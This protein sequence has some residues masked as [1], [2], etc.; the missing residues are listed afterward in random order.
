MEKSTKKNIL[1]VAIIIL[2][3]INISALATIFYN[4]KLNAP[5][6]SELKLQQERIQKSGMYGYFRESLNLSDDQFVEFKKINQEYFY[7]TQDIGKLLNN[8]R[9]SLLTE[10]SEKNADKNK[11][12]SIAREIGNLHYELKLLTSEHFIELKNLCND[13]QQLLLE[14]MFFK[15]ISDQDK[16]RP[17]RG[18]NGQN[19]KRNG[20]RRNRR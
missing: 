8:S 11:I 17:R 20:D 1:I 2:I 19:R 16:D 13:D 12:D 15:M 7:K 6:T 9:H 5:K 4:K 14:E 3:I 10:V 18:N